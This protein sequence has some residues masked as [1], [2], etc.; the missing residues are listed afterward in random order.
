[1]TFKGAKAV[2]EE[3]NKYEMQNGWQL[4]DVIDFFVVYNAIFVNGGWAKC[5]GRMSIDVRFPINGHSIS[6]RHES[7][8]FP[9]ETV[10]EAIQSELNK[11]TPN[12]YTI[13]AISEISAKASKTG[14]FLKYQI[15]KY[16]N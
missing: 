16:S 4:F 12:Q 15:V 10:I 3:L 8:I 11:L 9:E 7:D 1:M 5:P 2:I 14:K 6:I 13:N